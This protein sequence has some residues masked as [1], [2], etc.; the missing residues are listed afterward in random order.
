MFNRNK[1]SLKMV[2]EATVSIHHWTIK[3]W[4]STLLR[5]YE[6]FH[7]ISKRGRG[8][9]GMYDFYTELSLFW[10]NY[11]RKSDSLDWLGELQKNLQ[12]FISLSIFLL[13]GNW[14]IFTGGEN[15]IQLLQPCIQHIAATRSFRKCLTGRNK[16]N[17]FYSPDLW[18]QT[19]IR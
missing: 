15:F 4:L 18:L 13:F 11:G 9:Y 16:K 12:Q 7:C 6:S 1:L 10:E 5:P 14:K 2:H 3:I 19:K 17:N 8:F